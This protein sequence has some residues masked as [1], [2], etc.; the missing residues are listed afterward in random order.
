MK[1]S[2]EYLSSITLEDFNEFD[3]KEVGEWARVAS[4]YITNKYKDMSFGL[5]DYEKFYFKSIRD[6][7]VLLVYSLRKKKTYGI[8]V[9][10][11]EWEGYKYILDY[12]KEDEEKELSYNK[13]K[14]IVNES[15]YY[16]PT[17]SR[18][19][20]TD[21]KKDE[22]VKAIAYIINNLDE[23]KRHFNI[24]CWITMQAGQ[25]FGFNAATE[26]A[27]IDSLV[28]QYE[29]GKDLLKPIMEID[30]ENYDPDA[31]LRDPYS[32]DYSY[33]DKYIDI[34]NNFKTLE[35][36]KDMIGEELNKI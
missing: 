2:Y 14:D 1:N 8:K 25:L 16:T 28:F 29:K 6:D 13:M 19:F 24:V 27:S 10:E 36:A 23:D 15:L 17:L 12:V 5:E 3:E 30:T 26:V 34:I 11:E 32:G 35:E 31:E 9:A 18:I 22:F 33:F 21:P 7:F 20:P 4:S